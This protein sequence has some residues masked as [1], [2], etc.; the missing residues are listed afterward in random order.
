MDLAGLAVFAAVYIV[1]TASPGPGV[2]AIVARVLARGERGIIAFIAGFVAGDLVWFACAAA[3]LAVLAQT[4]AALFI[5]IKY[6]GAA[7]LLYLAWRLWTAPAAVPGEA[8]AMD[9]ESGGRLFAAGLAITL[10]NPKVIVFFMA[11]LPTVVDLNR[12]TV[13]GFLEIGGLIVA[14]LSSVLGAYALAAGRARR[15]I[16][17][18]RAMRLV[19]RGTGAVMAGAAAAIAAR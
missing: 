9:Q 15:L 4:F 7:Y 16:T 8:T 19:N 13:V 12:L 3:G 11:L 1:A 6:A 14:I 2:A 17:S 10:G 18:P 5:A